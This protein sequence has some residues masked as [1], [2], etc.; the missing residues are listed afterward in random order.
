MNF[1]KLTRSEDVETVYVN[2]ELVTSMVRT[3]YPLTGTNIFFTDKFIAPRKL[4]EA[5]LQVNERPEVI[6]NM[7]YGQIMKVENND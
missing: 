7:A 5:P 6:I 1:V 4:E 2:L 3:E